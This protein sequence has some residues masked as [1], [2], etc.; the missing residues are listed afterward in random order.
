MHG[1]VIVWDEKC[2]QIGCLHNEGAPIKSLQ[3]HVEGLTRVKWIKLCGKIQCYCFGGGGNDCAGGQF[4]SL[5]CPLNG[6]F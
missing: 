2:A 3:K 1:C 4:V 5:K 6:P